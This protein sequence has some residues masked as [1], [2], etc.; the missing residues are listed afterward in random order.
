MTQ[1]LC[2]IY[3]CGHP[4]QVTIYGSVLTLIYKSMPNVYGNMYEVSIWIIIHGYVSFFLE[5]LLHKQRGL[6]KCLLMCVC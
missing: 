1:S 5:Q 6:L 3:H 2:R 4:G